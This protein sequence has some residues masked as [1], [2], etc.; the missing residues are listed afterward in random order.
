M[1]VGDPYQVKILKMVS[2][3]KGIAQLEDKVVFIPYVLPE[4]TVD[5][6]IQEIK[7]DYLLAEKISV[8]KSS[9]FRVDSPCS[10]FEKCG[11]CQ[12]Q[13][14]DYPHQLQFK[15]DLFKE[16]LKRIGK[17]HLD[18]SDLIPASDPFHYRRKVQ[19]RTSFENGKIL[20]GFYRL[21]SKRLISIDHCLIVP[22]ILNNL[23][24]EVS[25]Y[26]NQNALSF[27]T[28]KETTFSLSSPSDDV[29]IE[30][31]GTELPD[32]V[33]IAQG[34]FRLSVRIRGI[35]LSAENRPSKCLGKSYFFNTVIN[36]LHPEET[37]K[38]R[39]STGAFS[40]V[41]WEMNLKLIET[42]LAWA[43]LSGQ[44]QLLEL[45]CGS[46]NF[47]LLMAKQAQHIV[48]VEEN[49][50]AVE[51]LR[52]NLKE[53]QIDN[54]SIRKGSAQQVLSRWDKK[55]FP[56][57][58]LVSDPPREGM[59][60]LTLQSILRILPARIIYISCDPATLARDLRVL[61]NRYSIQRIA[62]FD[63]FPQTA[64]IESLTELQLSI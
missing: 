36:P 11:G 17:L 30:L 35:T 20:I 55:R 63:M 43:Q 16:T 42:L 10:F 12:W 59:D 6:K 28:L 62:L 46:G 58:L 27:K 54:C 25:L 52:F 48:A 41:N 47:T 8:D 50:A 32:K 1:K 34:L 15:S 21:E 4:E 2:K 18:I 26:L 22:P 3:G 51:D 45:Y 24:R 13:M 39:N 61:S 23:L 19:F 37:L 38:I 40:Q 5:I 33:S 64:H 7:K 60:H 31:K 53:N 29:L 14:I 9:P 56:V 49:P 57:D 44:E